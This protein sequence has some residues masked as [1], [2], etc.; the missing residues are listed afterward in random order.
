MKAEFFLLFQLRFNMVATAE[1][2][3]LF[4]LVETIMLNA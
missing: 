2:K 1:S 3:I 4:L